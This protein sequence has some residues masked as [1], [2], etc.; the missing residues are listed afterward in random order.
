MFDLQQREEYETVS[1]AMVLSR[2]GFPVEFLILFGLVVVVGVI[3]FFGVLV[4]MG[5]E[6]WQHAGKG[7]GK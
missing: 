4:E 1:T 7:R 3:L 6:R 2:A 5:R